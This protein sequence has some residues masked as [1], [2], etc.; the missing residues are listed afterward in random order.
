MRLAPNDR[1]L[2]YRVTI[3]A[4]VIAITAGGMI[5]L[6]GGSAGA[7][8]SFDG[9]D[10]SDTNQTVTSDVSDVQL[11]TTVQ[12]EHDVPDADRRQIKLKA[13][14]SKDALELVDYRQ[15]RDPAGVASGSVELSGSLVELSGFTAD[16]FNPALADTSSKEIVIQAVIE[17]QRTNGDPVIHTVT[18]T[19]TVTIQDG[20]ELTATI[21]GNGDLTVETTG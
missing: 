5:A 19:A 4:V 7:Q 15:A 1:R 10:V 18:D 8:V 13:G 17:V 20:A 2:A 6:S 14:P 12:Y 11:S 3:I 16:D 21:T 9:L